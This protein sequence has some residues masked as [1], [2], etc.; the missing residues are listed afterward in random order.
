MAYLVYTDRRNLHASLESARVRLPR[1]VKGRYDLSRIHRGDL[2]FLVDYENGELFGPFFA[3]SPRVRVEK[4]PRTGPFNGERPAARYLYES[5]DID[6]SQS[7]AGGIPVNGLDLD[8]RPFFLDPESSSLVVEALRYRNRPSDLVVL[9]LDLGPHRLK[10]TVVE[11]VLDTRGA[12]STRI[13]NRSARLDGP[14][15]DSLEALRRRGDRLLHRNAERELVPL[16]EDLGSLVHKQLLEELL[17]G[18]RSE[19]YTLHIRGGDQAL[20]IPFEMAANRGFL[21][22]RRV[23][24][25]RVQDEESSD[26]V[27]LRRVLIIADPGRRFPRAYEEGC[28]LYD[29]FGSA[30]LETD[31]LSR[32]LDRE[33]VIRVMKEYDLVH[34]AGHAGGEP[35]G[36]DL[37]TDLLQTA[38]LLPAAGPGERRPALVFSSC[39]GSTL[40]LGACLLRTGTVNAVASRWQHPDRDMSGFLKGFYGRLLVGQ[41]IGYAFHRAQVACFPRNPLSGLFV[42][43]GESRV[44]YEKRRS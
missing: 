39:C 44:V 27:H 33:T 23:L 17:D 9:D 41:E 32:P 29:L 35:A 22:Q 14:L 15:L 40:P 26:R 11:S 28:M 10:A 13:F 16:L 8:E 36:W 43:M 12:L 21:F 2:V 3:R 6:C 30:G 1:T 7:C 18:T 38:C 31:L 37:G 4:N 34:F 20:G 5:I 19:R 24:A 42:L 25:F